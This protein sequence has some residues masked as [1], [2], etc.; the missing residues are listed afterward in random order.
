MGLAIEEIEDI[1]I[2]LPH[3]KF[4]KFRAWYEKFDANAWDEQIESDVAA[5]KLDVLAKTAIS[6]HKAG[7]TRRL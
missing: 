2:N 7:K 6:E 5:G 4:K 1:I 3:D